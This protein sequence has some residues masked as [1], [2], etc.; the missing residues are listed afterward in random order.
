MTSPICSKRA[1]NALGAMLGDGWY[2]GYIGFSGP[3]QRQRQH[4]GERTQLLAQLDVEYADGTRETVGT[5][6]DWR[7]C[8]RA[9]PVLRHADGRN[10]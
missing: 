10:V 8:G 1:R 9:D 3:G 6:G 2:T 5:D 4:Y 7:G